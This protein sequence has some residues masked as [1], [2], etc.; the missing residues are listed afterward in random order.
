MS[1]T[2][3]LEKNFFCVQQYVFCKNVIMM[4]EPR[5]VVR[6]LIK[7]KLSSLLL[8]LFFF[9][10]TAVAYFLSISFHKVSMIDGRLG[11]EGYATRQVL[12]VFES[13]VIRLGPSNEMRMP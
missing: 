13:L 1:D 4:G 9:V 8:L 7:E 12:S 5:L 2:I 11:E 10:G 3:F 6:S